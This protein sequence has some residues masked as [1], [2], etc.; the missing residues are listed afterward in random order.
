MRRLL[1]FLGV[2]LSLSL[3]LSPP[4][5]RYYDVS[6]GDFL[7]G[8]LVASRIFE[9]G[10]THDEVCPLAVLFTNVD[11]K[12]NHLKLVISLR[13][14]SRCLFWSFNFLYSQKFCRSRDSFIFDVPFCILARLNRKHFYPYMVSRPPFPSAERKNCD[15]RWHIC[16][17]WKAIPRMWYLLSLLRI[18]FVIFLR[19]VIYHF[20][21]WARYV[22]EEFRISL[23]GFRADP[24]GMSQALVSLD[25][26]KF[27]IFN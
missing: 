15:P 18:V 13:W 14:I 8:D 27:R 6:F 24:L 26:I 22:P 11:F 25:T 17:G 1:A 21:N 4:S 12:K 3:S 16:W 10:R 23:R 19:S 5:D 2:S 7:V 20:E 9:K